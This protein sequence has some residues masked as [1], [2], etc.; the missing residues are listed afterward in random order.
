MSNTTLFLFRNDLRLDDNSALSAACKAGQTVILLYIL[1]DTSKQNWSIGSASRWWLHHSLQSLDAAITKLGGNLVLRKGNS[2]TILD[3]IIK[4]AEVDKL[5]FSRTYDPCQREIEESIYSNWHK[6]IEIKRYGGYLLFEPEQIRTGS[7]QVYKVFTPFWK[8]CLKQQE[9]L[10][11]TEKLNKK[12]SFSSINI[13]SDN[14]HDWNLLPTKPDWAAGFK[15]YWQPGEAAARN[16][17]KEFIST[18]IENYHEDRDRPD[19]AGTSR[20]SPYLHFGEISPLRIWHEV[21]Q[22]LEKNNNQTKD[23][24]S[25]LRELGWRDFSAHLL[26]NW[27][28]L[29]ESPFRKEYKNFPWKKNK[30]ALVAWQKGQTGFPIVDAGMRELWHTG[31]MHNRVRMIVASFLVKHLL[32]HWREGEEWFWDT[33]VDADLANNAASWQ[34]VAGSGADAAPYFRVFNPILQGKKFDPNGDYV[35]QWIPEIRTVPTKYIHEPWLAATEDLALSKIEYPEPIIDHA[36]GRTRALEA[37]SD[38]KKNG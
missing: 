20:M 30:K 27:S 19:R 13:E 38:F 14:L 7:D 34:W 25:Y 16:V 1:D 33:L 11:P 31:W 32:I 6:Q 4:Q 15:T 18:G 12:I 28:D 35:R 3:E 9:P 36:Y 10:L 2:I 26:F 17:L 24:M 22:H 23:G 29:P 5:Y 8:T 21:K 37:Y